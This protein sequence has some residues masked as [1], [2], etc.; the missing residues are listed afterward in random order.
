MT[1]GKLAVE[2]RSS[3]QCMRAARCLVAGIEGSPLLITLIAGWESV[4]QRGEGTPSEPMKSERRLWSHSTV[5][6]SFLANRN[7]LGLSRRE[8]HRALNV[9][10][11]GNRGSTI[12]DNN[13][14]ARTTT[15]GRVLVTSIEE[16]GGRFYHKTYNYGRQSTLFPLFFICF[17]SLREKRMSE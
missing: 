3:S 7:I 15:K 9:A 4:K 13:A 1:K 5:L 11:P 2:N 6:I 10:A 8:G 16:T 12:G 14:S 17:P